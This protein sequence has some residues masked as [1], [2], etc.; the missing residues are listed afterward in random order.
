MPKGKVETPITDQELAFALL[1]LAG[2]L[3]D[4]EA[5]DAVGLGAAN[6]SYVK[7]KP[8]VKEYMEQH[9]ASVVAAIV[10]HESD[11]LAEQ[12]I[13]REQIMAQYWKLAGLSPADT[14]GNITGQVRALDSLREMLG[15]VGPQP[16][17]RSAGEGDSEPDVYVAK[18]M[19]KPG[20]S[21]PEDE[22]DPSRGPVRVVNR[23]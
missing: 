10:Q 6:A 16:G 12:N 1:L 23:S 20:E 14:N 13:G 2:K 7:A 9:R 8:R 15:L 17:E 5:A 22:M 4:R 21:E 3:T 11:V 19:R 18:W